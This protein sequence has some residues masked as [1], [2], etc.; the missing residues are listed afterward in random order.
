[1]LNSIAGST[2]RDVVAPADAQQQ[3]TV[4]EMRVGTDCWMTLNTTRFRVAPCSRTHCGALSPNE[5]GT[6][7]STC[8][9]VRCWYSPRRQSDVAPVR[10]TVQPERAGVDRHPL[11]CE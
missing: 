10:R 4:C 3:A 1:M 9:D 7:E 6:S 5:A 11:R 8:S 2:L